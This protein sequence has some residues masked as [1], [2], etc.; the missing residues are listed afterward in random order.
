MER[1]ALIVLFLLI[2]MVLYGLQWFLRRPPRYRRRVDDDLSKFFKALLYDDYETGFLVIEAPNKKR[3]IQFRRYTE[4]GRPG[5]RFDFPLAPW[6][7][8]YYEALSKLLYKQG[9][10]YETLNTG[11]DMV[12]RFITIDFKQDLVRAMELAML[13]LTE[14]FRLSPK[15]RIRVYLSK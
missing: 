8:R 3:F 1:K 6:S 11:Q 13:V 12:A 4:D 7:E 5:V 15:N 10:D 9:I 14:V 2:L